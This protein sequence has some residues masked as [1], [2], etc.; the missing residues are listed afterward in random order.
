MVKGSELLINVVRTNKLK[1]LLSL[2]QKA[3]GQAQEAPS[4][5][6]RRH[7]VPPADRQDLRH[8][9]VHTCNVVSP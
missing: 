2:S 6:C 9:W 8:S 3:R 1:V 7:E 5:S 4:S